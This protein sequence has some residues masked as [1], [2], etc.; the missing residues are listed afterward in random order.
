MSTPPPRSG[1]GGGL[2]L[3]W[4]GIAADLSDVNASFNVAGT[5]TVE[6]ALRVMIAAAMQT[7]TSCN[8]AYPGSGGGLYFDGSF[9]T[10][11]TVTVSTLTV[12]GNAATGG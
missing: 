6:A 1:N 3:L 5:S 4:E 9:N 11:G 12:V 2:C 8:R 7:S 10:Q